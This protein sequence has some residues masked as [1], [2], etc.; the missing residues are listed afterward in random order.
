M[1]DFVCDRLTLLTVR[2]RAECREPTCGARSEEDGE[3]ISCSSEHCGEKLMMEGWRRELRIM[4][5]FKRL[6]EHLEQQEL[7]A[8]FEAEKQKFKSGKR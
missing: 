5:M 1:F 6:I 8:K 4:R 7:E 3:I 2:S